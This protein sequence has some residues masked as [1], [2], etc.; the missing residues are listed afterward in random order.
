M[1]KLIL[2]TGALTLAACAAENDEAEMV[3][4]DGDMVVEETTE[5][6]DGP[7]MPGE[8]K[9]YNADGELNGTAM[10]NADGTYTWTDADGNAVEGSGTWENRD[11][12]MCVDWT[13][14]EGEEDEGETCWTRGE[15]GE[16]GRVAWTNDGDEPVTVYVEESV[17]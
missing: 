13:E 15:A 2:L 7:G 16:D 8:Y 9:I 12:K 5:V 17:G 10:N 6:A 4:G 11:G 1:K 14:A 3:D